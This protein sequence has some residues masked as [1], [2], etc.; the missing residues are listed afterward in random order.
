MEQRTLDGGARSFLFLLC[1]YVFYNLPVS[2]IYIIVIVVFTLK[3]AL[4]VRVLQYV[5]VVFTLKSVPISAQYLRTSVLVQ[6][7]YRQ[8]EMKHSKF[9]TNKL[10]TAASQT[11]AK[12]HNKSTCSPTCPF[13]YTGANG[14][15]AHQIQNKQADNNSS[16]DKTKPKTTRLQKKGFLWDG[17]DGVDHVAREVLQHGVAN[18]GSPPIP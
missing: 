3:S 17:P 10:T 13:G 18:R 1:T 8:T 16:L 4:H 11:K 5:V 14:N 15:E 9:K 7:T 12:N 6:L 2:G